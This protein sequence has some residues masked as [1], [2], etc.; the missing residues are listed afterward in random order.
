MIAIIELLELCTVLGVLGELYDLAL[1]ETVV[2]LL[3]RRIYQ[4]ARTSIFLLTCEL[5]SLLEHIASERSDA[6][7]VKD[8][9]ISSDNA[10][11]PELNKIKD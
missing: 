3:R 4:V 9:D 11:P 1:A 7:L 8:Q 5:T 6:V 10:E 2:P